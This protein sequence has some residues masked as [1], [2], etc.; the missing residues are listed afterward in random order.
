MRLDDQKAPGIAQAAPK[1]SVQ[2]RCVA[3]RYV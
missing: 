1:W 3:D 2:N